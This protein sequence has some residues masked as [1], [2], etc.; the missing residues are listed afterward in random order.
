MPDF[1]KIKYDGE[2]VELHYTT[3]GPNGISEKHKL[4]SKDRPHPALDMALQELKGP[5]LR[6]MQL[7]GLHKFAGASA[8]EDG[9]PTYEAYDYGEDADVR[10][11]SIDYGTEGMTA[12][13]TLVKHLPERD[14]PMSL[15]TP[16]G[17]VS[18]V[19]EEAIDELCR[20]AEHYVQ[21]QRA[22]GD[23][24]ADAEAGGDGAADEEPER[25][26]YTTRPPSGP[27]PVE[28]EEPAP[29]KDTGFPEW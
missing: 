1:S 21:G 8:D 28:A 16:T 2:K 3:K 5:A 26:S 9:G 22:Q 18:T 24:F 17:V 11:V 29:V 25:P 14:A 13:I 15:T 4:T 12:S 23:M 19:C 7:A 10:A 20:K 6:T 27:Q